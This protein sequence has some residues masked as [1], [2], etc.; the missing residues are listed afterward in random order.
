MVRMLVIQALTLTLLVAATAMPVPAQLASS[1]WPMFQHDAQH[2]GKSTVS[3]PS[4]SAVKVRWTYT[5]KGWIKVQVALG[6]DGTVYI[7]NAK[8]PL[9]ALDPDRTSAE[10]AL[11]CTGNLGEVN[12]S[13]PAVG[14]PFP[15]GGTT[16]DTVYI[17]ERANRLWAFNGD[18]GAARWHFRVPIDGDVTMS[19]LIAGDGTIY[20]GCG[21][22]YAAQDP[23]IFVGRVYAFAASPVIGSGGA[24][25]P[26]WF[27][28]L[29]YVRNSSPAG[30]IVQ[31][32]VGSPPAAVS[33][34]R[35]YV[36]TSDGKL[37]AID[38]L[39]PGNG[40]VAWSLQLG[41][42]TTVNK[43]SSPSIGPDGT[44]YI[45][46]ST[47]L[48]AVRDNG[49]SGTVLPGWPFAAGGAGGV[50]DTTAAISGG[51]LYVSRYQTGNRTL[52][53]VAAAHSSAAT[54]G[55][56]LWQKGPA[57]GSTTTNLAQTPSAVVG[58]NGIVY[59]AIGRTVYAFDPASVNPANPVWQHLLPADAISLTVGDGVLYVAAKN[60]RLYALIDQ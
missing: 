34:L 30:R 7:G 19:P 53:A 5:G 13:S 46:T 31:F 50:F 36:G 9:C 48:F 3:G 59:A 27:V 56:K 49:A 40:Q 51:A 29:P 14:N 32:P 45:G 1:P 39:G 18:T 43:Q 60:N 52:Y 55:T 17:G 54:P 47:G 42:T 6:T 21:C 4:S 33:R 41:P 8:F 24:A 57:K 11:W 22:S 10:P 35:L 26:K 44:I 28:E 2:T 38:D 23:E 25:Q 58:A 20:A 12:F 16:V 37:V 15:S